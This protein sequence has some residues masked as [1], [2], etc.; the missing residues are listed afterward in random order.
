M[1]ILSGH[2]HPFLQRDVGCGVQ[3]GSMCGSGDDYTVGAQVERPSQAAC[4]V[5]EEGI[6]TAYPVRL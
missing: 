5:N 3:S 1:R 4:V 2:A 6:V